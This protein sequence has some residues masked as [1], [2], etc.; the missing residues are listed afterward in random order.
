MNNILIKNVIVVIVIFSIAL[1]SLVVIRSLIVRDVS[2]TI[3]LSTIYDEDPVAIVYLP[4]REII[5]N[6]YSDFYP[7][8]IILTKYESSQSKVILEAKI[9][10]Y[11]IIHLSEVDRGLYALYLN[12]NET[13]DISGEIRIN[14]I[15][16]GYEK[17]LLHLSISILLISIFLAI[18][19]VYYEIR[20]FRS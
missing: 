13:F 1:F 8:N 12:I 3:P 11:E 2:L 5:I 7:F 20:K 19:I 16:Y 6:V 10:K 15:L 14:I 4:P 17:D 18:P 9:S